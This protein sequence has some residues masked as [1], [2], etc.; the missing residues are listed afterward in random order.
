MGPHALGG[1]GGVAD[2]EDV[3]VVVDA[4]AQLVHEQGAAGAHHRSAASAWS[5]G[6]HAPELVL[7]RQH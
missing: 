7:G 4:W 2:A 6:G 5:V 1:G 3:V